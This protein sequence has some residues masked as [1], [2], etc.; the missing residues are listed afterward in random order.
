MKR[1]LFICALFAA[2]NT[3]AAEPQNMPAPVSVTVFILD[4]ECDLPMQPQLGALLTRNHF[5]QTTF[6]EDAQILVR[7]VN[8]VEY[9]GV[10]QGELYNL[11]ESYVNLELTFYDNATQQL[12][13]TYSVQQL[14]VLTQEKNSIEQTMAQCSRELFKRVQKE[15]P[16]QLKSI[17]L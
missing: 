13:Y 17:H 14:R 2:L 7:A 3:K 8:S 4:D 10:I 16:K 9:A 1:L 5:V 12:L 15:L 11:N 6:E